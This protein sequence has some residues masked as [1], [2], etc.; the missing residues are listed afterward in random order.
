MALGHVFLC[1]YSIAFVANLDPQ[2]QNRVSAQVLMCIRRLT[3]HVFKMA[4][5]S[6]RK[7]CRHVFKCSSSKSFVRHAV[8][9]THGNASRQAFMWWRRE[10]FDIN[11]A[12]QKQGKRRLFGLSCKGF[13]TTCLDAFADSILIVSNFVLKGGDFIESFALGRVLVAVAAPF[14]KYRLETW[15]CRHKV[16]VLGL[17]RVNLG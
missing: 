1:I 14:C 16:I 10:V 15:V 3:Y 17:E 8:P 11:K 5:Q 4:P 12:P 6:Q 2:T 9:Q 7:S 13:E